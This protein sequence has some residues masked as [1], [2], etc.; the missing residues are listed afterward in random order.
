MQRRFATPQTTYR[1]GLEEK[2]AK[3]IS[4]AGHSVRFEEQKLRYVIPQKD[5]TYTPDFQLDNGIIIET[6]GLFT[7]EDRAKMKY[8]KAQHPELDIRMVF[9]NAMARISKASKT[10]Y[11]K[12]CETNGFPFAHRS[13]PSQWFA[14]G[15]TI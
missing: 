12:W 8:V 6:K 11:A 2:I 5:H 15:V 14:E 13:I 7:S 10:T 3:Q 9:S 4:E 1:S